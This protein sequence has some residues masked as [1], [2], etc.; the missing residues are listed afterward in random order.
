MNRRA[1]AVSVVCPFYNESAIL[2]HAITTMLDQ[3]ASF[4]R[5]WELIVVDDGSVDGGGDIARRIRESNDR[6]R[7]LSYRTN[8]GRGHALRTGIAAA[9]GDVIVTTEIDLS[10]GED[11]V[12]RLVEAMDRWPDADIVVASPNVPG[13]AYRNVPARRVFISKL[14]NR[15]IRAFVGDA[16][17]MNTGMTRAYRR[18]VIRMLPLHEDRKEFHLEVIV[19]ATS[20]GYRIREIPAILEWKE[21]K[22]ENQRVERKSSSR[23]GKLVISHSLFSLFA[24]PIQYVWSMALISLLLGAASLVW[25]VIAFLTDRVA[26]YLALMSVSLVLLAIVLF[27]MGVILR[28]GNMVQREMWLL[29]R[30]QLAR[31]EVGM[32]TAEQREALRTENT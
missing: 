29:Q 32:L 19:K 10:W 25:A 20:F 8:R 18:N 21:Y 28:Q 16:V 6:L 5:E 27:V 12:Q 13:G 9:G 1:V 23:V 2:E 17:T 14:G 15:V 11:I 26:A 22:H 3:L 24:N 7:V 31:E 4:D 30:A